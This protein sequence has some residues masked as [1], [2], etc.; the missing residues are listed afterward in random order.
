MTC[1]YSLLSTIH[2]KTLCAVTWASVQSAQGKLS[3]EFPIE[4]SRNIPKE[5]TTC[6]WI[7][8]AVNSI[9][10]NI[11]YDDKFVIMIIWLALN[12]CLRGEQIFKIYVLWGNKIKPFSHILLLIKDSLQCKN[13]N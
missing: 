2:C 8:C 3:S 10:T 7:Y 13:I 12:L 11:R 4:M 9:Y 5:S 1:N 6:D